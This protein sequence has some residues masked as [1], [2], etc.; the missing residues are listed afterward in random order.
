VIVVTGDMPG[1][2][3]RYLVDAFI[4]PAARS[5]EPLP[6]NPEALALLEARVEDIKSP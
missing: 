2:T 1:A 3:S 5:S 6:E 4:L